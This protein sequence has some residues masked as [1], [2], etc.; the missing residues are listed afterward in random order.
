ALTLERSHEYCSAIL[1]AIE[2]NQPYRFNGNVR[3][4]G[5]IA[6]L[7]ANAV[8]EVPCLV[9]GTGIHPCY[10]GDLPAELAGLNRT[11]LNVQ[12]V[13]VEALKQGDRELVHRAILLDPLT[14]AVCSLDETRAM[15][16]ELFE[17]HAAILTF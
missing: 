10:V 17:A 13:A 1:D 2:S 15:V 14:A 9:D 3:N 4:H 11:N 5:V 6:N 12:E 8:V 16:D 7:P